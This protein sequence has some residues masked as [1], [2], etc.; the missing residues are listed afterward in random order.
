MLLHFLLLFLLL[1][2]FLSRLLAQPEHPLEAAK[3]PTR[4]LSLILLDFGGDLTL[5][6]FLE[7]LV[8]EALCGNCAHDDELFVG[9]GLLEL[10][11]QLEFEVLSF[12]G[13]FLS[14]TGLK[15]Q[16]ERCVV[17]FLL[18]GHLILVELGDHSGLKF[19]IVPD[20]L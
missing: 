14:Q 10:I 7:L 15:S 2:L 5:L 6:Q 18:R 9:E 20:V 4:L 13:Q 12:L 19:P 3:V 17:R 8:L 16:I 1:L 11:P